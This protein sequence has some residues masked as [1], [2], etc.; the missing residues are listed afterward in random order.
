MTKFAAVQMTAS[1]DVSLNLNKAE[2]YIAEALARGAKFV[3][4]PE[5]FAFIGESDQDKLSV[6]ELLHHGHIQNTLASLAKTYQIWLH[7]GSIPILAKKNAKKVSNTSLLWNPKGQ[8]VARYDKIH[9]FDVAIQADT[10]FQYCES[11]VVLPGES[12]ICAQT[13]LGVLGFSICYD[14]RFP[15]LYRKLVETSAEILLVPAAFTAVTGAAHWETLLRARAIENFCFVI[16]A[17]QVGTHA[18]QKSSY[19]ASMIINPWGEI[20]ARLNDVEGVIV[21]DI[22]LSEIMTQRQRIP[23]LQN[24]RLNE[25][26]IVNLIQIQQ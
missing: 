21:A 18:N 15:E 20:L 2:K 14:L 10:K 7:G 5:D 13:P 16:A 12:L 3:M 8:L 26:S 11:N 25:S 9:L 4:L 22:E 23:A 24:K 6:G 17:N 19:G 1:S